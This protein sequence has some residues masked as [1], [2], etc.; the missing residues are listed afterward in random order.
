M[1]FFRRNQSPL[2]PIP[3]FRIFYKWHLEIIIIR[4][5]HAL[6]YIGQMLNLLPLGTGSLAQKSR[7]F[8][9]G[10]LSPWSQ[11]IPGNLSPWSQFTPGNLSPWSN[12]PQATSPLDR[13]TEVPATSGTVWSA[14]PA[15]HTGSSGRTALFCSASLRSAPPHR[16]RT[17]ASAPSR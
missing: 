13:F 12:L 14:S 1:A 4:M 2:F 6:T 15:P 17:G 8:E 10:N 11:F 5:Q 3:F 7:I 9:P 16:K